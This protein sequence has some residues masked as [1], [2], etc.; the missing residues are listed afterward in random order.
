MNRQEKAEYITSLHNRLSRAEAAVLTEYRG[1]TVADLNR[2]RR[3]LREVQG[4]YHVTKN[5]LLRLAITDTAFVSLRELLQG[6]NGLVLGY[7]DPAALIKA[8]T[9]Y[10]KEQEKLVV[11][12][13][14]AEGSF[15]PP[16][17]M[18][19]VARLPSREVLLAQLLGLIQA[20]ATR[21]LRTLNEPAARLVRLLEATRQRQTHPE[22]SQKGS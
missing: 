15:I 20:P 5:R 17:K 9:R 1:L 21:L 11:K 6:Q 7:G 4:E 12:G 3:E 22:H 19:E 18:E 8:V 16:E 2:L 13:G 14:V 10:A